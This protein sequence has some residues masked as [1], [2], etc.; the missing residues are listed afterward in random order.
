VLCVVYCVLCVVCC[1]V[2]CVLCSVMYCKCAWG[3]IVEGSALVNEGQTEDIH[4]V[5]DKMCRGIAVTRDT[6]AQAHVPYLLSLLADSY[7]QIGQADEGLET[8]AE[9]FQLIETTGERYWEGGIYRLKGELLLIDGATDLVEAERCFNRALKI[10]TA[11]SAKS[12]ELRG[13][14]S[15]V[16][17]WQRQEKHEEIRNLLTPIYDWFTE[18]FDTVDL[19]EAKTLLEQ[20]S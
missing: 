15:L 3:S 9:A 11:Q 12:L 14:M 4:D 2:C 17:L 19:K 7:W 18:G 16:H 10:A 8:V 1:V 20:L 6:G 13:A 5:I